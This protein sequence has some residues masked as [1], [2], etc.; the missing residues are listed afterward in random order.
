[1]G[2][3]ISGRTMLFEI[4]KYHLKENCIKIDLLEIWPVILPGDVSSLCVENK[5]IQLKYLLP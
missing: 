1:M 5:R 4:E 3:K 2:L